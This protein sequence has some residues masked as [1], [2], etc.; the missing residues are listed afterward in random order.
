MDIKT[1]EIILTDSAKIDLD[2][3]YEYIKLKEKNSANRLMD[4]I[5]NDIL[6]LEQYPYS[7]LEVNVKPHKEVYRKLVT[8]NYIVLYKIDEKNKRVMI[9]NI[10]Y[11]K[12][13]YLKF[14]K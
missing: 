7:C 8:E 13:D 10:I 5:E 6:K 1:Y 12:R 14:N 3:I 2:E 9:F 4:K 11:G